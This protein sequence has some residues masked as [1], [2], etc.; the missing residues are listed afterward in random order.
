[1]CPEMKREATQETLQRIRDFDP[2]KMRTLMGELSCRPE[3]GRCDIESREGE[4]VT[5]SR[6]RSPTGSF[7][8][9]G[10]D[11]FSLSKESTPFLVVS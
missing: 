11:A 8:S 4:E 10:N 7:L 5:D 2:L 9:L 1:M 6:L 3:A